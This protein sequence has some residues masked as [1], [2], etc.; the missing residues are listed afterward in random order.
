MP[1]IMITDSGHRDHPS[2]ASACDSG[3]FTTKEDL[4]GDETATDAKVA[5]N[6]AAQV[7]ETPTSPGHRARLRGRRRDGLGACGAS[8]AGR[9]ELALAGGS[10]RRRVGGAA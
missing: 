9:I 5:R 10:G 1:G 3:S 7:R 6:S 4:D 8:R 2:V